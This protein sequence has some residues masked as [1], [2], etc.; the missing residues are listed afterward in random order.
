M[1]HSAQKCPEFPGMV[2][3]H[4]GKVLTPR[5]RFYLVPPA[6][7]LKSVPEQL[8]QPVAHPPLHPFADNPTAGL[9]RKAQ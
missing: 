3:K 9:V 7:L 4:A 5:M 6:T 2:C 1:I 8:L